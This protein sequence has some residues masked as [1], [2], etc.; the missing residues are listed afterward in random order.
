MQCLHHEFAM[1][2]CHGDQ[3]YGVTFKALLDDICNPIIDADSTAAPD[4]SRLEQLMRQA[5]MLKCSDLVASLEGLCLKWF[6]EPEE[7][8]SAAA[9]PENNGDDETVKVKDDTNRGKLELESLLQMIQ[10][11]LR[12]RPGSYTELL[13]LCL[14]L[15]IHEHSL[16]RTHAI[17]YVR[18]YLGELEPE[19]LLIEQF[20]LEQL[21]LLATQ[22]TSVL[23][24]QHLQFFCALCTKN[25]VL[26]RELVLL[27]SEFGQT[28]REALDL[29]LPKLF[30]A[31]EPSSVEIQ[32]LIRDFLV[33][34]PD[35]EK[36]APMELAIKMLEQLT[37]KVDGELPQE[38]LDA[39][40]ELHSGCED[41]QLM[42][43]VFPFLPKE[44]AIYQIATVLAL[45]REQMQQTFSKLLAQ[46]HVTA[47]DL[48]VELHNLKLE[49]LAALG[50]HRMRL[51]KVMEATSY[52]F[53]SREVFTSEV[54]AVVIQRLVDQ[55]PLPK[56]FMRTV[57]Q[58]VTHFPTLAEFVN[59]I[60][61]TL[62]S[63][64][65]WTDGSQWTGFVKCCEA[66]E[67]KSIQ[68]L[69]QLPQTQFHELWTK[70]LSSGLKDHIRS[71]ALAHN[72]QV[73]SDQLA[74]IQSNLLE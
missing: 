52:C 8:S 37:Q 68:V 66:L 36:P 73:P 62:V 55:S 64:Q 31:L 59:S 46:K 39:V 20:A 10:R 30:Q 9:P 54:F 71:F 2:L 4:L 15:T 70:T 11:V 50:E 12:E 60:L 27:Y 25:N 44:D 38:F 48:L 65:I 72:S 63:K 16:L 1:E 23:P 14:S 19:A 67:E 5:P 57:I 22:Q 35:P 17:N 7:E 32:E 47:A 74:I 3:R 45:P 28:A 29:E 51:H 24:E 41:A 49:S 21:K 33:L 34:F 18:R 43:V 6:T 40:L 42:A 69:L 61:I 58:A 53:A 56:L 26:L 13:N